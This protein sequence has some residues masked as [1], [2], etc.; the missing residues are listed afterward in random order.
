MKKLTIYFALILSL[1]VPISSACGS[2]GVAGTVAGPT[3]ALRCFPSGGTVPDQAFSNNQV[4]DTVGEGCWDGSLTL[5]ILA[6]GIFNTTSNKL[7]MEGHLSP[8]S[9]QGYSSMATTRTLGLGA[10][11]TSKTVSASPGPYS[12]NIIGFCNNHNIEANNYLS[13]NELY[14]TSGT[15]LLFN[16]SGWLTNLLPLSDTYQYALV[17]GGYDSSGVPWHSGEAASSY[18]YGSSYYAKYLGVWT[19]MWRDYYLAT[20][21][22]YFNSNIQKTGL[23]ETSNILIPN[24]DF[25]AV[26]Q[27]AFLDTF[28]GT[29]G[30]S[31]ADHTPD[32]ALPWVIKSGSATIQSNKAQIGTAGISTFDSGISNVMYNAKLTMP[33]SGTTGGGMVARYVDSTHY[34]YVQAVAGT[35][36]NVKLV[37]ANGSEPGDTRSTASATLSANTEYAFRLITSSASPYW[38]IFVAGVAKGTYTTVGSSS[39]GTQFGIKD[40]GNANFVGF[41]VASL[42]ARTSTLYDSAFAQVGY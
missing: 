36:N 10:L 42:F 19:L 5:T 37:E 7:I 23:V 20:T 30:T 38:S 31:L 25:S 11:F 16:N 4:L 22:V 6:D 29:D 12:L 39:T 13:G 41:D 15:Y 14:G 26:L 2:A 34:W 21:P 28:T 18:L 8:N 35:S 17:M 24:L 40:E 9:Q 33:A 32:V 1:L 27:P 3:Y